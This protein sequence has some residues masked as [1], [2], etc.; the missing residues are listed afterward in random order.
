MP[1]GV[2]AL[3]TGAG[4]F[5]G[6]ALV[7]RLLADG[8]TV[9]GT[10]RPGASN[11]RLADIASEIE[12]LELDLRDAS[13]VQRALRVARPQWVFNLATYGGYSWQ[14]DRSVILETNV[15]GAAHVID[16]AVAAQAAA[17]V[18]AGSSSEFGL[19]DHAPSENELVEPNSAYA[20]AKAAATMYGSWIAREYHQAITTLRLYSIYGPWEDPRRLIPTLVTRALQGRLPPLADPRTS[21]DFVHIDDACEAFVLAA[22]GAES[23]ASRIYNVASGVQ[24]TLAEL[25]ALARELFG[26]EDEPDWGHYPSRAWDTNVWVGNPL[27]IRSE[28]GWRA[29]RSLKDGLRGFADWA[30][31][32]PERSRRYLD[33]NDQP[34]QR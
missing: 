2:R 34:R 17:I 30:R 32:D 12:L 5:V 13:T 9:I 6:S 4:G 18:N 23:G 14:D 20:V 16:A 22:R 27:R 26:V 19:K 1:T 29:E 24:T 11:W 33:V 10:T 7:R 25:V 15:L 21:R 8:Q 31:A 28:L 3:V